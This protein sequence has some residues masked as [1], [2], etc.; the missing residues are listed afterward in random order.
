M[1]VDIAPIKDIVNNKWEAAYYPNTDFQGTPIIRN[2]SSLDL[3]WGR[4][5][6][7]TSIPNDN[8]TATFHKKLVVNNSGEFIFEGRADDGVKI[9]ID[10][11]EIVNEWK[12]GVNR[13]SKR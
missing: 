8:F 13:Y 3:N 9:F 7:D 5:S 10:D 12:E 11:K 2:V 4:G 1:R 6:P